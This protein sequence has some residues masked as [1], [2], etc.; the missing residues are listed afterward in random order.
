MLPPRRLLRLVS[1][2]VRLLGLVGLLGLAF[3]VAC[4]GAQ[5]PAATSTPAPAAKPTTAAVAASPSPS[6]VVAVASPSPSP[7]P[8]RAAAAAPAVSP[9]PA[10]SS[11]AVP[12]TASRVDT[13]TAANAAFARGDTTAAADLYQRVVTTPP[14]SGEAAQASAT[15]NDFAQFRALVSLLAA[16]RETDARAQLD[17]LQQRDPNSAFARLAA[18]LWDQ[19]SM[20][21]QLRAA[22]AQVQP[23]VAGQA[24]AALA[25]LQAAGVTGVDPTSLCTPPA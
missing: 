17:Q 3:S 4:S 1:L 9:S 22:C 8:T 18:Q 12:V 24:G 19:Y 5:P 23:Q 10:P 25:A 2:R 16:R 7:S 13:L 20:T 14:S 11:A 15:I 6:A 21:G